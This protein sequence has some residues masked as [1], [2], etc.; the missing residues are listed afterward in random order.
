MENIADINNP[1]QNT[2][3]IVRILINE[4]LESGCEKSSI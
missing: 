4:V 3:Q 1:I 2:I